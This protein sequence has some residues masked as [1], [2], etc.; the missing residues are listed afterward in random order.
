MDYFF[1]K[2]FKS[3]KL[4][5]LFIFFALITIFLLTSSLYSVDIL[6]NWESNS[7]YFFW[8]QDQIQYYQPSKKPE[9]QWVG[10]VLAIL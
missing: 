3:K 9:T 1:F 4:N 6:G 8:S 10:M 5:N 7:L 2:G